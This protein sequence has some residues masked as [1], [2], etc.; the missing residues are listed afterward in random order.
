MY[1]VVVIYY[2]EI[3]SNPMYKAAAYR[4]KKTCWKASSSGE[5][6]LRVS[7]AAY[8]QKETCTQEMAVTLNCKNPNPNPTARPK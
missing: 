3:Q 8:Q 5:E 7:M 6:N 4:E 2:T 1:A